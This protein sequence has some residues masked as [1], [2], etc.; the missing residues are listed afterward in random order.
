M[1]GILKMFKHQ[2]LDEA[3][4][5]LNLTNS[6]LTEKLSDTINN[7][8]DTKVADLAQKKLSTATV[9]HWCQGTAHPTDLIIRQGISILLTGAADNYGCFIVP[10]KS[11]AK[12]I[13]R[14]AL[15]VNNKKIVENFK[16]FKSN[17]AS[18]AYDKTKLDPTSSKTNSETLMGCIAYLTIQGYLFTNYSD[19]KGHLT[20]DTYLNLVDINK[21]IKQTN[22]DRLLTDIQ[23]YLNTAKTYDNDNIYKQVLLSLLKQIVHQDFWL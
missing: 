10:T 1:L 4:T 6:E 19:S 16:I 3:L 8:F 21:L 23:I 15:T 20:L 7:N 5:S 13:L 18:G 14:A 2:H 9:R 17:C 11:E 12:R 22:I